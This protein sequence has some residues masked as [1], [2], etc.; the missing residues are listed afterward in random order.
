ML[1]Q[2]KRHLFPIIIGICIVIFSLLFQS[3]EDALLKQVRER[4]EWAVY[5]LRLQ[6][7]LDVNPE[8]HPSIVIIDI[9]EKSLAAEG[10]FPWPRAKIAKLLTKLTDAGVIVTAFDIFFPEAEDNIAT[11]L[12]DFLADSS[13]EKT[14]T[15]TLSNIAMEIDGDVIFAKSLSDKEVVMGFA[16]LDNDKKY[17]TLGPPL[18]VSNLNQLL[19]APITEH[20]GHLASID[21]LQQAGKFSGFVNSRP[22]SDGLIRRSNIIYRHDGFIYPSLALEAV[23]LFYAVDEITIKTSTI[24]DITPVEYVSLDS[25]DIPTDRSGAVLIPFR[26]PPYSFRYIS[27]TD[28]LNGNID[29]EVLESTIAFIGTSATGLSDIRPTPIS[30]IYP[31]VEVHAS[32]AA[33]ILDM[34]FPFEPVW[35]EGFNFVMTL[36]VGLFLALLLP[37]MNPMR[38]VILFLS[39]SSAL[40]AFNSWLWAEYQFVVAISSPLIMVFLLSAINSL[41]GFLTEAKNKKVLRD[42]FS[43]YIPPQLVDEMMNS[44]EDLG[45][46]GERREMTVL[47]AD[48][49]NFTSISE[50]L[51]AQELAQMLN[52]FFTPMTEIIFNHRGTIDKYVGDM[53]MAFWG[54]PLKDDDHAKHALQGALAMI[55]KVE[56]IKPEMKALGYPEINLGV[57]LNTGQMNVGNMGSDFR[58]AYTVLG[59]SVNL[60]SRLESLTKQYGVRLI[61]GETTRAEQTDF[62]FRRLDKVKV[63]GKNEPIVIYEP[64]CSNYRATEEMIKEVEEFEAGLDLYYARDWEKARQCFEALKENDPDR[65]IYSIYLDR[66]SASNMLLLTDDWDGV[67]THTTK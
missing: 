31:G 34:Q 2:L 36:V 55:D 56:E 42:Q 40:I 54:A 12:L 39:V 48:I 52:K 45:F 41:Y 59:D 58:R 62:L 57:G 25:Y 21:L 64:L 14:V 66:M 19:Y 67:F 22:D 32:I 6:S 10:Q 4:L 3:T 37:F 50:N 38:S 53:I 47:F 65:L 61:V 60:G 8:P 17:G 24:S 23:R 43:Q 27:A 18:V 29:P 63:K 11:S 5:D 20:S 46:E 49:R 7:T 51:S 35:A 13:V 30:S 16:F 9:D 15:D 26:G 44:D 1:S 33:G 28:V